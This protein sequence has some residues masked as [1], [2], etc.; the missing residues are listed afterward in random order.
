MP[1]GIAVCLGAADHRW[2]AGSQLFQLYPSLGQFEGQDDRVVAACTPAAVDHGACETPVF[3]C[4]TRGETMLFGGLD[5]GAEALSPAQRIVG[6]H[7]AHAALANLSGGYIVV[8]SD[9]LQALRPT[10]AAHARDFAQ[11]KLR[12]RLA[13]AED[14]AHNNWG[15][16]AAQHLAAETSQQPITSH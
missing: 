9:Q 10:A 12:M 7:D 4:D 3:R 11:E 16:F 15:L 13:D 8:T 5:G 14:Y 1:S 2:H 6:R